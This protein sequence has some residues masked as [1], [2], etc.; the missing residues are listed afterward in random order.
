MGSRSGAFKRFSL[1]TSQEEGAVLNVTI[2]GGDDLPRMNLF[3]GLFSSA[4]EAD[5]FVTM[6]LGDATYRTA[7]AESTRP[8]WNSKI[9]LWVPRDK[10]HWKLK[11][12]VW[13]SN[14]LSASE[15]IGS[16][17]LPLSHIFTLPEQV[18]M[19][20]L[21]LM[22][23][24]HK[25]VGKLHVVA[26]VESPLEV[27]QEF[28]AELAR[29]FSS[30]HDHISFDELGDMLV[31]LGNEKETVKQLLRS[32]DGLGTNESC[33]ATASAAR[34]QLVPH[35][36]VL[37]TLAR[38][39]AGGGSADGEAWAQHL[40]RIDRDPISNSPFGAADSDYAKIGMM[41]VRMANPDGA[42]LTAAK[43]SH[44]D[45]ASR[46]SDWMVSSEYGVGKDEAGYILVQNRQTGELEEEEMPPMVRAAIRSM[47]K[48]RAARLLLLH[49][50]LESI[51]LAYG[52]KYSSSES[53]AEIGPFVERYRIDMGESRLQISDFKSFNEFFYRQLKPTA[54]P[55]AHP[56][57]GG[58]AVSPSD[59]RLL[60]FESVA[61]ATSLWIKGRAFTLDA[62]LQR[63]SLVNEFRSGT[64][65]EVEAAV[66]ICRLAPQDYHRNHFPVDG[67][68]VDS[69]EIKGTYYT[70]NPMAV[71]EDVDVFT[72]N[73]RVV[74]WLKSPC[75]GPVAI[76]AVGAT[77][78]GSVQLVCWPGASV[79]K[80]AEHSFFAFGGST[81]ILVFKRGAIQFDADLVENSKKMLE[82]KVRM[83][84]S[85][86]VA[87]NESRGCSSTSGVASSSSGV[88]RSSA[89]GKTRLV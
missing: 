13:N 64:T 34:P 7:V 43:A 72:E 21:Q 75:F 59:C 18:F 29:F 82:T 86:G 57:D 70:V 51:T 53:I 78:V 62:L 47:Y 26:I 71:R 3:G 38:A 83:G 65:G 12:T 50:Q 74:T 56:E 42:F 67:E 2:V 14:L 9:T 44:S 17:V 1:A 37:H 63:E 87:A 84:E 8:E 76:V 20:A 49:S 85:I 15:S 80:G 16:A 58:V 6:T 40:V 27:Q 5:P 66:S 79:W 24:R 22:D 11:F 10:L 48:H 25:S 41:H 36:A 54:R 19:D 32:I 69:W 45:W 46:L 81:V 31:A 23:E 61:A 73:K 77:M 89:V 4:G 35:S 68:V 60:A 39:A 28:W 55:I 88:R 33:P 52:T 30:Q